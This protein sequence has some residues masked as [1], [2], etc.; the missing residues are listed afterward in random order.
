MLLTTTP[1]YISN[2]PAFIATMPP[3]FWVRSKFRTTVPSPSLT[4]PY[5]CPSLFR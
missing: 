2:V 3:V 5:V 1:S 4:V